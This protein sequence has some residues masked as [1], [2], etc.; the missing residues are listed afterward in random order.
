[1]LLGNEEGIKVPEASL[2]KAVGG[3]LLESH[4]KK[5]LAELVS[6]LVEGV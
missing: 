5:D 3:H 4:L 6:D 2:N 1:M